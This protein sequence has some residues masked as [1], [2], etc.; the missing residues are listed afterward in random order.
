MRTL[1]DCVLA[2]SLL[3]LSSSPVQ[4]DV[5]IEVVF[6]GTTTGTMTYS[7]V[8]DEAPVSW[9]FAHGADTWNETVPASVAWDTAW[10]GVTVRQVVTVLSSEG[11]KGNNDCAL[12][13]GFSPFAGP[14]EYVHSKRF[15]LSRTLGDETQQRGNCRLR[16]E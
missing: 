15:L 12:I 13:F 7:D 1:I 3:V 2:A 10:S 14:G 16:S 11:A 4:A 6:S 5:V 8:Y 9:S